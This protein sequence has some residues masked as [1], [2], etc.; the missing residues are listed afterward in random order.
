MW[1]TV[2][3]S[4]WW[5]LI[6]SFLAVEN[7]GSTTSSSFDQSKGLDH[8]LPSK[9]SLGAADPPSDNLVKWI[10][11]CVVLAVGLFVVVVVIFTVCCCCKK[12]MNKL[13]ILDAGRRTE[14]GGA[15]E[16]PYPAETKTRL[17][18]LDDGEPIRDHVLFSKKQ[19]TLEKG[20][21]LSSLD[22]DSSKTEPLG[23]VRFKLMR[24]I[25]QP[26]ERKKSCITPLNFQI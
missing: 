17:L 14:L 23:E 9:Y 4:S 11:L 20:D 7:V 25:V 8:S 5:W 12:K 6:L 16:Y 22:S 2:V 3:F 1:Q 19:E 15:G 26:I 10:I 18:L 13:R 21:G 24:A